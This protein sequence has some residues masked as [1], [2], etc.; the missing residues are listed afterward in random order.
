MSRPLHGA[1][2]VCHCGHHRDT[3]HGIQVING[4]E[5]NRFDCLGMYCDCREYVN[6]FVPET[7]EKKAWR[8][9][10]TTTCG[11]DQVGFYR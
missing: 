8:T 5:I 1:S 4:T 2:E 3:H 6:E 11:Q 7:K 9:R 10:K